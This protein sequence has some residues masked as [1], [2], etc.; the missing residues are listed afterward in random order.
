MRFA[1]LVLV[2]SCA[3]PA[4]SP[5]AQ[6]QQ[7]AAPTAERRITPR[8]KLPDVVK[9]L[10]P[11]RGSYAAGGGLVSSAWRVVV[12]RDVKTIYA[13]TATGANAASFGKM[14]KET[15]KPLS[16]RNDVH[17]AEVCEVAWRE[18]PVKSTD[19][20]ADYDEILIIVDGDNAFYLQGFGP[21]KS[22]GAAKAIEELRAAAGL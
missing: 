18:A 21:I 15:T 14:D 11:Q 9:P 7:P 4:S 1:L 19:A 3:E 16:Q 8:D 20:T 12:D 2:A 17:L 10:L 13:G 6:P 5:P 22:P